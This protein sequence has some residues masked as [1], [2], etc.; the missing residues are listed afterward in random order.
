[1][2]WELPLVAIDRERQRRGTATC[3]VDDVQRIGDAWSSAIEC[4]SELPDRDRWPLALSDQASTRLI[5]TAEGLYLATQPAG[6]QPQRRELLLAAV[7][8]PGRAQQVELPSTPGG[9]RLAITDTVQADAGAWC[10]RRESRPAAPARGRLELDTA[11][12]C[13]RAGTGIVGAAGPNHADEHGVIAEAASWGSVPAEDAMVPALPALYARL[14]DRSAEWNFPAVMVDRQ[15]DR[16]H[17]IDRGLVRCRVEQVARLVAVAG[18]WRS[19]VSCVGLATEDTNPAVREYMMDPGPFPDVAGTTLIGT[20]EGL[21]TAD[22][23]GARDLLL[24]RARPRAAQTA[25]VEPGADGAPP[26]RASYRMAAHGRAWCI[27]R[28]ASQGGASPRAE[29]WT[30]C[31]QADLG[32]V[33]GARGVAER[34]P[35]R[36]N[37]RRIVQSSWGSVPDE[38]RLLPAA[39]KPALPALYRPLFVD[40]SRWTMPLEDVRGD[41]GGTIQVNHGQAVCWIDGARQIRGGYRAWLLC[42]QRATAQTD[43]RGGHPINLGFDVLDLH[44]GYRRA[45]VATPGGLW[46][47]PEDL[48]DARAL[49]PASRL[50]GPAPGP[51]RDEHA[52]ATD[53]SGEVTREVMPHHDAWCIRETWPDKDATGSQMLCLRAGVGVVGGAGSVSRASSSQRSRWGDLPPS[54]PGP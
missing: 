22:P 43:L 52:R 17:A 5:G 42:H 39:L 38:V 30:L 48:E 47:A 41:A 35:D 32:I 36:G 9:D 19:S 3:T 14:F 29:N 24:S 23:A 10:V 15:G 8:R 13:L 50:L 46:D 11:V 40:G 31:L 37:Q 2:R 25:R 27:R 18:A 12:L 7:P 44:A 45:L 4:R 21:W 53:I 16:D 26:G 6:G 28:E 34:D 54:A 20:P 49:D 1:M 51:R 33:G